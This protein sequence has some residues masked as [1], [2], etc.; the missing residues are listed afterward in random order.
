M[1]CPP[2]Q[3]YRF[4]I[5]IVL[6]SLLLFVMPVS[7]EQSIT[8]PSQLDQGILAPLFTLL[9]GLLLILFAPSFTD[10]TTQRILDNPED[11][12]FYGI[13]LGI[14]TIGLFVLLIITVIGVILLP[15]LIIFMIVATEIGFLATGRVFADNWAV[16][17]GIAMGFS[18]FAGLI[19]YLGGALGLFLGAFGFGTLYFEYRSSDDSGR[20]GR[21]NRSKKQS[22]V[23]SPPM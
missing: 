15:F 22:N 12:F 13:G 5:A 23:R 4:P 11:T 21:N 1:S 8:E 18:T 7:A 20:S 3:L 17:L 19:P 9:V 14:L 2:R 16:I 10:R 6:S